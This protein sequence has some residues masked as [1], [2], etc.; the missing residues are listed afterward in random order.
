ME[1]SGSLSK[2]HEASIEQLL[3]AYRDRDSPTV[4]LI[5]G[6][7]SIVDY[8]SIFIVA[9]ACS[10]G[11]CDPGRLAALIRPDAFVLVAEVAAMSKQM[12]AGSLGEVVMG[13]SQRDRYDACCLVALLC[14]WDW[15]AALSLRAQ[16]IFLHDHPEKVGT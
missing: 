1:F 15:N 4:R 13:L 16:M 7:Q 9:S 14:E 8:E 10:D 5:V 12:V 2:K 11:S 3:V 6:D